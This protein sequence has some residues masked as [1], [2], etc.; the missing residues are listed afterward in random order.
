MTKHDMPQR[1]EHGHGSNAPQPVRTLRDWLDHLAA[2]YRL[3]VLK[4]NLD[5][6]FE[7]AAH[8]KRL[9]GLRATVFPRPGGHPIPVVS[10]LISDRG[11]VAAS[12]TASVPR[13]SS[14]GPR[15]GAH[16]AR[17]SVRG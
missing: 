4:P 10:G 11:W 6:K 16:P 2:R 12:I 1:L 7:L 3:A 5:L 15:S 14:R 8:A 9:D 17:G 13:R